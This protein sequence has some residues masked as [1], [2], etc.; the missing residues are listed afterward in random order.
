MSAPAASRDAIRIVVG[1]TDHGVR[2]DQA[3]ARGIPDLS[4]RRARVAIDLGGVFVDGARTK[5]ASRP[6]RSG[7]VIDVNLGGVFAQ[8]TGTLG[9]EARARADAALPP[10]ELLYEDEDL[11]VVDKPAGLV[12]APTPESDRGNLAEQLSQRAGRPVFVVHRLDR[13]TSGVLVVARTDL[14][15]RALGAAFAA[16]TLEREYRAVV[17]GHYA[18]PTT[19]DRPVG[20]R[21]AVTHVE[22]LQQFADATLL[23]VTLETGRSH[24]IRLHTAGF[25]HPVAGD[26]Q[27]GGERSR[28]FMPRPPRLALHAR[29]L[30]FPHPRTGV[31]MRFEREMPDELTAWMAQLGAA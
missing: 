19:I 4:R 23:R 7:Q 14:A 1:P 8:T 26:T 10:F 25:G 16:H 12:T 9:A 2:L 29:V 27:H 24:Q 21:R 15:N 28:Q 31:A 3:L 11:Y 13:P 6:V 5:V 22:P 17:C 30:G 18:G 20:G